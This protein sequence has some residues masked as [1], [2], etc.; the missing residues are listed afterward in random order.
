MSMNH[1]KCVG[2]SKLS[3]ISSKDACMIA[4]ISMSGLV[5]V[6]CLF[7]MSVERLEVLIFYEC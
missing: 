6:K 3:T 4:T 5:S 7:V 1:R 2:Y